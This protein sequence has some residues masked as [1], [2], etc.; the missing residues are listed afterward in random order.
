MPS[1]LGT[2][3][4]FFVGDMVGSIARFP[5][6]WYGEGVVRVV[7]WIGQTLRYRWRAYAIGLWL[8]HFFVPMYGAHDWM[9]RLISVVM[10]A[11]VIGARLVAFGIETATFVVVLVI[12]LFAPVVCALALL[13]NLSL[14]FESM[15]AWL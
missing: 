2:V 8:R 12:W 7:E 15:R 11:V 9:S 5:F 1:R 13:L 3:V 14:S 6:W 4:H 10:R